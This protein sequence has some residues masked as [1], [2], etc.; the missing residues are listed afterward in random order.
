MTEHVAPHFVNVEQQRQAAKLG[1]WTFVAQEILFFSGLFLAYAY[2]RSHYPATFAAA[3]RA[4]DVRLGTANTAVLLISS[5]TM[6][7]AAHASHYQRKRA[8]LSWL[9]ATA[10]LGCVFLGI[11]GYEYAT[12]IHEGFLPG[13]WYSGAGIPGRPDVFFGLYFALTGLHGVHV[14][15]GVGVI[16]VLIARCLRD[17]VFRRSH[18][19][20][21]N[22]GLYWHFVD[23]VWIFLFPL[24]YLIR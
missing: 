5:F 9:A 16:S 10:A 3:H 22:V 1:M 14:L 21:E 18:S 20:I 7:S 12:K 23:I 24:L 19:F 13:A 2:M 11:K 8:C 4:L 15:V 6:V 17:R